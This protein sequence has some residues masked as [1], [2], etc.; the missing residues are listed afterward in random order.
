MAHPTAPPSA[1]AA[2]CSVNSSASARGRA[3]TARGALCVAEPAPVAA[4]DATDRPAL[5]EA[6]L[7]LSPLDAPPPVAMPLATIALAHDGGSGESHSG[8]VGPMWIIMG[9]MMAVMMVG[10]AVYVMRGASE[11]PALGPAASPPPTSVA[12]PVSRAR[13]AGG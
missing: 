11:A 9:V 6:R 13:G 1:A 8:H 5:L 12:L 4:G 2:A 7:A 10:M 3:P